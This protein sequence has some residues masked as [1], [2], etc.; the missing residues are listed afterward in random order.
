LPGGVQV[1]AVE[2]RRIEGGG[3]EPP[4]LASQQLAPTVEAPPA[5]ADPPDG[6]QLHLLAAM[7]HATRVVLAQRQVDGAPG[8]VPAFQPLLDGLDLAGVVVTAD[9]A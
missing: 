9:A 5:P 2:R 6:R 7:D 1:L 4:S 3:G 8:E